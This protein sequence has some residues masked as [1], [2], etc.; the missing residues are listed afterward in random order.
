MDESGS[1][2]GAEDLMLIA[3]GQAWRGEED[4]TAIAALT[5]AADG[6]DDPL[7][8]L[9]AAAGWCL[10]HSGD[11]SPLSEVDEKRLRAHWGSRVISD[12]PVSETEEE[13][14]DRAVGEERDAEGVGAAIA[15]AMDLEPA[16][17]RSEETIRDTAH[18]EISVE[19]ARWRVAG[20]NLR[21][22]LQRF[23]PGV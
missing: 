10:Q 5:N 18:I 3:Y 14:I 19:Q 1:E 2:L 20:V 12:R 4:E 6:L 15:E 21:T 7:A 17:P 9:S 16:E 23:S 13:Q 22:A 11:S 8:A